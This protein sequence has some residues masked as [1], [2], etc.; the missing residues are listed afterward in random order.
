MT[1]KYLPSGEWMG[2]TVLKVMPMKAVGTRTKEKNGYAA[3]RFSM[4][5]TKSKKTIEREVRMDEVIETGT[6]VAWE[7]NFKVGD[8]VSVTGT[9]K[10]K[11]FA[12]PVKRYGFKGGPRTHGQSDRERAPGSS[13]STTTPGRVYK[14]KRRAGHMGR[15]T[16]TIQNSEIVEIDSENKRMFVSGAVP[17]GKNFELVTIKKSI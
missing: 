8:K 1:S 7:E 3:M 17:G 6:E 14:G 13:G 15:E 11:G 4:P 10:G 9:S 2:V 5:D 12:G 16:V